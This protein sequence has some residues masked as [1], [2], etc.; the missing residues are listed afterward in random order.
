VTLA[1]VTADPGPLTN[2]FGQA[3]VGSPEWWLRRLHTEIVNRQPDLELFDAYYPA[4]PRPSSA[5]S[6]G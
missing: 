1:L 2:Q 3:A 4:K 6:C 5:G